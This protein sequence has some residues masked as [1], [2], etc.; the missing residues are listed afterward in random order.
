M[1]WHQT[2][3]RRAD[4]ADADTVGPMHSVGVDSVDSV[5]QDDWLTRRC[6]YTLCALRAVAP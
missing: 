4:A 6:V 1:T 2:A 5:A 3:G